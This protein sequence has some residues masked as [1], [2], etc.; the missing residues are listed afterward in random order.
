MLPN[1]SENNLFAPQAVS[2]IQK[3]QSWMLLNLPGFLMAFA[4]LFNPSL[5]EPL[6][7]WTGYIAFSLLLLVLSIGPLK[8]LIPT[9]IF[10]K[11]LGRYKR[12]IGVACFTYAFLHATCFVIKRGGL[13]EAFPW[14]AHPIIAPGVIALLI[15]VP[16]AITSNNYFVKRMGHPAWKK[17]HKKVYI[18]E[19]SVFIH[20]LLQGDITSGAAILGV[21]PIVVL[22]LLRHRKRKQPQNLSEKGNS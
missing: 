4:L 21:T 17:L 16:L 20:M 7:G 9:S 1:P 22:Q 5:W 10:F 6:T 2:Y 13:L 12:V 18:A 11:K 14:I 8:V 3:N 19:G 15:F